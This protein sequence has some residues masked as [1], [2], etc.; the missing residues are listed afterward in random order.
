ML[1]E[2]LSGSVMVEL[3]N[4]LGKQVHLGGKRKRLYFLPVLFNICRLR[5]VTLGTQGADLVDSQGLG[6][7]QNH[8]NI[9]YFDY[10]RFLPFLGVPFFEKTACLA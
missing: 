1:A 5:H 10:I 2:M 8:P 6:K 7:W 9:I 3:T 4:I